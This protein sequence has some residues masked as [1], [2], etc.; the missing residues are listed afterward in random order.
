MN[1]TTDHDIDGTTDVFPLTGDLDAYMIKASDSGE[2]AII[3]CSDG[4]KLYAFPENILETLGDLVNRT[5]FADAVKKSVQ[6]I[7]EGECDVYDSLD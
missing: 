6:E 1:S 4:R 7:Q 2:I 3:K 5:D